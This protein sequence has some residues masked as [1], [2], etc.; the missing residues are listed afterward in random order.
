MPRGTWPTTAVA[1]AAAAFLPFAARAD[2]AALVQLDT[3]TVAVN[4]GGGSADNAGVKG[5]AALTLNLPT[6]P[7]RA[8]ASASAGETPGTASLWQKRNAKVEADWSALAPLKVNVAASDETAEATAPGPEGIA[9][10]GSQTLVSDKHEASASASLPLGDVT[11]SAAAGTSESGAGDATRQGDSEART[12]VDTRASDIGATA[13]WQLDPAIGVTLGLK[14]RDVAIGWSGTGEGRRTYSYLLPSAE[15]SAKLWPGADLDLGAEREV[16]DYGEGTYAA[17]AAMPG[18]DAPDALAPDH[19][20]T[21]RA[22]LAQAI[23]EVKLEASL[24]HSTSGTVT[25]IADTASGAVP[26]ST[27]LLAQ[28]ESSLT[29]TMP[30]A[31]LGLERFSLSADAHLASSR[32]KDPVTGELRRASGEEPFAAHVTLTH[33]VSRTVSVGLK[34]GA[35]GHT[36]WYEPD[37]VST[38]SSSADLGA[39]VTYK[40]GP[41]ELS[42]SADGL[43]GARM[44][45]DNFYASTRADSN[46]VRS[47]TRPV[48]GPSFTLA[49]KKPL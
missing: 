30:L 16:S 33:E 20:W 28:T 10:H 29:A 46:I 24:S 3:G 19:A 40:P 9:S 12:H 42:L 23:G 17:L 41:F 39:F 6:L 15:I 18:T 32:V 48:D 27:P 22:T 31:V 11:L 4:V 47:D 35:K 2:D 36:A 44:A 5:S 43:S 7:L 26:A 8:E 25:E 21:T 45:T 14:S 38:V 1:C 49:L 13:E 37:S 34:A